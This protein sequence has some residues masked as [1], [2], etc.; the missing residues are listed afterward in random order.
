MSEIKFEDVF[1]RLEEIVEE[2]EK[3]EL[4]LDEQLKKYEEGVKLTRLLSERLEKAKKKVSRLT[5]KSD[6]TFSLEPFEEVQEE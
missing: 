2:L 5:K 1:K 4:S 6:G 3:G